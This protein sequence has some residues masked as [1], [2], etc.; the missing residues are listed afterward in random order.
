MSHTIT[1]S[2]LLTVPPSQLRLTPSKLLLLQISS[3]LSSEYYPFFLQTFHHRFNRY[4]H[5]V[6]MVKRCEIGAITSLLDLSINMSEVIS[7]VLFF[8]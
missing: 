8:C 5:F 3:D 7:M 6:S 2:A 1:P 4:Y